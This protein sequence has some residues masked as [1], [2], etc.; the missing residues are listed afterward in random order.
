M[1]LP[2]PDWQVSPAPRADNAW[3][4]GNAGGSWAGEG[5]PL[6]GSLLNRCLWLLGL[7]QMH[8]MRLAPQ[9]RTLQ[10]KYINSCLYSPLNEADH[11]LGTETEAYHPQQPQAALCSFSGGLFVGHVRSHKPHYLFFLT[12]H[13]VDLISQVPIPLA[14][15]SSCPAAHWRPGGEFAV[16][17]DADT[18]QYMVLTRCQPDQTQL[19]AVFGE[20]KGKLLTSSRA[21]RKMSLPSW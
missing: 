2:R 12:L 7:L 3:L 1:F 11:L 5:P 8:L 17:G 15:A 20:R 18:T 9:M 21:Q 4:S 10:K 13:P 6:Y 19:C 16:G 14:G